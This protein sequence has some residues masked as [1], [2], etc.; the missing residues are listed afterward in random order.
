M[1]FHH[2]VLLVAAVLCSLPALARAIPADTAQARHS[3]DSL[4]TIQSNQLVVTGTR[5]E[6]RLKDSPVRVEVVSKERIANTAMTDLGDV[7]KEQTGLMLTGTVRSGIQMN[8]LGPDYTLILID[9]QPVIGRV[10]GVLER[11]GC[12]RVDQ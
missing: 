9:G 7:L 12:P 3:T 6:V 8:G 2:T 11:V 5:N 1:L 10:A 4:R